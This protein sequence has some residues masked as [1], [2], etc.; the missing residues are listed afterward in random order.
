MST[1]SSPLPSQNDANAG[2]S[3]GPQILNISGIVAVTLACVA[4]LLIGLA[5]GWSFAQTAAY[6]GLALIYLLWIVALLMIEPVSNWAHRYFVPA[7][8]ISGLLYLAMQS[9]SG[10]PFLQPIAITVPL[11]FSVMHLPPLRAMAT[12]ALFVGLM[13]LGLLLHGWRAPQAILLPFAGYGAFSLFIFAIVRLLIEQ[14][15]ARSRADRLAADLARQRDYLRHMAA[16]AATLTS[17]LELSAVLEQVAAAGRDLSQAGRVRVWLNADDQEPRLHLAAALPAAS[18]AEVKPDADDSTFQVPLRS[19]GRR[20]GLLELCDLPAGGGPVEMELLQPLADAAAVAIENARLYEQA[21]LSATLGERNRLARELHD[22]IAQ[23]LTAATMQI[24]A[25]QRAFD[26][27]PERARARLSRAHE[28]NRATLDD[29]RRSVWSLAEPLAD[30]ALLGDIL[31]DLAQRFRERSG[32]TVDYRAGHGLT[33][34]SSAVATQVV[35]IVQ[36]ALTNVE[37]HAGA[38]QV[39]LRIFGDAEELQIQVSDDGCG[40]DV[41]APPVSANGSGFGLSSLHER[42]RLAGGRLELTSQPGQGTCVTLRLPL[43]RYQE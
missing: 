31:A 8:L 18:R 34:V 23:G 2:Q 12:T 38:Q 21:R 39:E 22:T 10:D 16:V 33:V 27:D 3:W 6:T 36:E 28:L 30:G 5:G 32:I 43:E 13:V 15:E 42:S 4:P 41:Q 19:K 40:F 1:Q 26:R 17:D 14:T 29:V 7:L 35:R 9:I 11:V 37:K 20:I 25:A 24:E